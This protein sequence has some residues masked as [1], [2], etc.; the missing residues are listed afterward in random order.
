MITAIID[1]IPIRLI[2]IGNVRF[3][4]QAAL[5]LPTKPTMTSKLFFTAEQPTVSNWWR[6]WLLSILFK[7]ETVEVSLP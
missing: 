5:R 1:C 4:L 6:A 3:V 2:R 7:K